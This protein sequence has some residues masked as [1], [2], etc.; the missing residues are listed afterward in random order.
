M[1][2][3]LVNLKQQLDQEIGL[4]R[5][6]VLVKVIK[7][8]LKKEADPK[9]A[10]AY[11]EDG[12]ALAYEAND[13]FWIAKCHLLRA[14]VL[15]YS[16]NYKDAAIECQTAVSRFEELGDQKDLSA[17]LNRM[18]S[19]QTNLGDFNKALECY[20][21]ILEI[22][23]EELDQTLLG[24]ALNNIGIIYYRRKEFD[25]SLDYYKRS[26]A[27]RQQIGKLSDIAASLNNMAQIYANFEQFDKALDMFQQSLAIR[28]KE[29]QPALIA[30]SYQNIGELLD[31]TGQYEEALK[32]TLKAYEMKRAIGNENSMAITL[33]VI[34]KIQSNMGDHD[35]AIF[36]LQQSLERARNCGARQLEMESLIL[37]AT[38][39][40]KKGAFENAFKSLKQS[41]GI[42]R[43]LF[44]EKKSRQIAEMQTRFETDKKAQEAEIY[45][46]KHVD[47]LQQSEQ[48]RLQKEALER[49][50]ENLNEAYQALESKNI[51]LENSRRELEETQLRSNRLLENILP[52]EAAEEFKSKGYII[53]RHYEQVSVLF[54]DFVGFT[55]IGAKMT[56]EDLVQELDYCFAAFDEIIEQHH[57]EKIKTI[58]DSYMCAG[59]IPTANKT[60]AMDAVQAAIEMLSWMQRWGKWKVSRGGEIWQ[61]RIGIH[62]GPLVAG[63][64]GK[65]RFA[66]DIWG[67]TV[68]IASRL[69]SGGEP[70]K[71]NISGATYDLIKDHFACQYRG[72]I[73]AKN[74]GEIDMYFVERKVD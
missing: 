1:N 31:M 70:G 46:L 24:H 55:Q 59:G 35:S 4:N 47:L 28:Q 11:V 69:E 48:I 50:T 16:G 8:Q 23:S 20:Y 64:I 41:I 26:L 9:Q 30:A 54:T 73:P 56:P 71:I 72:K 40:D 10:L 21:Q 49:Q 38:I 2:Q 51:L 67:D 14:E 29:G 74:K 12:F 33:S 44:N 17:S 13:S 39:Y 5:L 63:V 53:P 15:F 19:I 62:T 65:K 18:G 7:L 61:L 43:E 45:R 60:N 6:P 42:E 32:H 3:E 52:D 27:V 34:G 22:D 68:N 37:L 36:Y 57:M 66:Y 58:G 25:K